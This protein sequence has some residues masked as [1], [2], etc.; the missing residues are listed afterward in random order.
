[1][2]GSLSAA[3]RGE[4][5]W[6]E[7]VMYRSRTE[8]EIGSLGVLQPKE[9]VMWSTARRALVVL[10]VPVSCLGL[11]MVVPAQAYGG[12]AAHDTWQA[13]LSFNCDNPDFCGTDLGGFWGWAE[14]DRFS[15]GSITGDAEFTGCSHT[16]GGG[17]AGTAGAGHVSMDITAAHIGAGGPDDPPGVMVFYVDHSVVTL[18]FGGQR[19]T[20]TD[21]P[22][23]LGDS[24]IPADPGH[25]S[26]HPAPAVAGEVQVA[27]RPAR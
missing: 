8:A 9:C 15:G 20:I 14:F 26:F 12:G 17:G 13:G 27:Y 23:F 16:T 19:V 11:G 1:M 10:G 6:P 25:Y 7:G 18:T 5:D 2:T 21:D 24:G 4:S 22:E 3:G